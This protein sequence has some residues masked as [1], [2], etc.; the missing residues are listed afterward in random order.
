MAPQ[1]AVKLWFI[2]A[3]DLIQ[4]QGKGKGEFATRRFIPPL[5]PRDRYH[6]KNQSFR[7]IS[8]TFFVSIIDLNYCDISK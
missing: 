2:S 8:T 4:P 5:I 3:G 1:T 6:M 7:I